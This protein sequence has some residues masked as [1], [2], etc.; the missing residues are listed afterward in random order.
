[1]ARNS[2]LPILNMESVSLDLSHL[3]ATFY[4]LSTDGQL[5]QDALPQLLRSLN[6]S[7]E[8]FWTEPDL[9]EML[10]MIRVRNPDRPYR[11]GFLTLDEIYDLLQQFSEAAGIQPTPGEELLQVQ[12]KIANESFGSIARAFRWVRRKASWLWAVIRR[13]RDGDEVYE[14]RMKPTTKLVISVVIMSLV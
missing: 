5:P 4:E 13:R 3:E 10:S 14:K 2:S 6:V 11:P 8:D 1:M 7:D 12:Q 9:E